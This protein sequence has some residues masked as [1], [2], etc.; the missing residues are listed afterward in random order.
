MPSK[1]KGDILRVD[2]ERYMNYVVTELNVPNEPVMFTNSILGNYSFNIC[3][4][5]TCFGEFH[6]ETVEETMTNTQ[7]EAL[8]C[9]PTDVLSCIIVN[10]RTN[11][12]EC[13]SIDVTLDSIFWTLYFDGS[14]CLEGAGAVGFN[15][16]Q[17]LPAY[18]FL[19]KEN[20]QC[21]SITHKTHMHRDFPLD[22]K[23]GLPA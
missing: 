9:N 10:D 19:N 13:S 12:V 16:V 22:P 14:N 8:P 23:T 2:R 20:K 21:E 11:F 18:E 4:T 7:L 15:P 17:K 5:K 6:A 1:A 3:A